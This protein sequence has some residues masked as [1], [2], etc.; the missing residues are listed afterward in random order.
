MKNLLKFKGAKK[1]SKL[2]QKNII[3]GRHNTTD[4]IDGG[5]SG[6][7]GGTPTN[8]GVCLGSP[9]MIP[10][11]QYCSDGTQPLCSN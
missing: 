9:I 4:P 1:L 11:D 3:G 8:I 5:G 6:G 10:C 7:H 2:E